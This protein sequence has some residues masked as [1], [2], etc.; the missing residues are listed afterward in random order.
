VRLIETDSGD[1]AS[2]LVRRSVQWIRGALFVIPSSRLLDK[3]WNMRPHGNVLL[4][5]N[6]K[7]DGTLCIHADGYNFIALLDVHIASVK[8]IYRCYLMAPKN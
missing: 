5:L 1:N 2:W 6:F 4:K 3:Y 7:A 8:S